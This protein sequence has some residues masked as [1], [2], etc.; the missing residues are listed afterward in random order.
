M[1]LTTIACRTFAEHPDTPEVYAIQFRIA[2][3]ALSAQA[4]HVQQA[5]AAEREA[6]AK[7]ADDM[8]A[9]LELAGQVNPSHHITK[10]QMAAKELA[11][12]IRARGDKT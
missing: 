9:N 6:C 5:I 4:A 7:I 11:H 2:A 8:A 1:S 3:D 10:T 12:R